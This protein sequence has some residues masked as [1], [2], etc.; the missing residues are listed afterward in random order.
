MPSAGLKKRPTQPNIRCPPLPRVR[1]LR[2]T[3]PSL[4]HKIP[5]RRGVFLSESLLAKK[6]EVCFGD[7][8]GLSQKKPPR[9]QKYRQLPQQA[10]ST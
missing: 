6:G 8:S 10:D 1:S 7:R 4:R 2:Q 5:H 3:L 9:L